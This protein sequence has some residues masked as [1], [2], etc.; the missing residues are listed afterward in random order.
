[1]AKRTA[2][3]AKAEQRSAELVID[4]DRIKR[5]AFALFQRYASYDGPFHR[6]RKG[7]LVY[8]S[9]GVLRVQSEAGMWVVLPQRAVWLPSQVVH[10]GVSRRTFV[11]CT[12]Y[13]DPGCARALPKRCC[14]MAVTPLVRELLLQCARFGWRYPRS[15]PRGRLVSALIEQIATLPRAPLYLP[16]PKDRRLRAISA[17]LHAAPALSDTLAQWAPRVGASA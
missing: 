8:V 4:P 17:A 5:P 2:H 13:V 14:V 9:E 7:Q 12:L 3:Q 1:M 16:E 15:G 6:H 11:L 10:R